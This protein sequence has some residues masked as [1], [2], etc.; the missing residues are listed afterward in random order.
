[1]RSTSLQLASSWF[2]AVLTCI[3]AAR[4][5]TVTGRVTDASGVGIAGVVVEFSNGAAP[6]NPVTGLDGSFV[7]IVPGRVYDEITFRP[8]TNAHA[9]ILLEDV[10]ISGFTNLGTLVMQPGLAISGVVTNPSGGPQ[11]GVDIDVVDQSTGQELFTPNDGTNALGQFSV[12]VPAGVHTVRFTPPTA[13]TFAAEQRTDVVVNAATSVGTVMFRDGILLSGTV[14]D[15]ATNQP[16]NNV[17]IDVDDAF[18]GQRVF[19]PNDNTDAMG[20][21]S[22]RVPRGLIHLS[23]DPAPGVGF[24]ASQQFNLGAS[25]NTNVGAIALDRG[26]LLRGAVRGPGNVP[27]ARVAV[28][29]FDPRGVEIY[30]PHDIT[31]GS[32]NFVVAV[33][34]GSYRL[35][36]VPQIASQLAGATSSLFSVAAGT[37][38]NAPTLNLPAGVRLS[39]RVTATGGGAEADAEIQVFDPTSGRQLAV[40]GDETLAD[41]S[42]VAWLPSGTWRVRIE[43]A[44]GSASQ[45]ANLGN[46]N[47]T[48]PTV[49]NRVLAA[50][51]ITVDV[52]TFGIPNV[53]PGGILPLNLTIQHRGNA[54]LP[55]TIAVSLFDVTGAEYPFVPPIIQLLFPV[56]FQATAFASLWTV[57]ASLP[58]SL[59]GEPVRYEFRL[60]DP[61]TG[62]VFDRGSA[63]FILR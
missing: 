33:P 55:A 19:T 4:A 39:G 8:P 3:G 50:A 48:A 28:S 57:P 9:P 61:T 26:V 18:S 27:V 21:F 58:A 36:G 14:V 13:T 38:A 30:T 31:D 15:R 54:P 6:A 49:L 7:L 62:A 41:G 34:P 17:D 42:Y 12:I 53:T 46:V 47:V 63:T 16:I 44:I 24:V 25:Q 37:T 59:R 60:Q 43:P 40:P 29:L 35:T 1:M 23:V 11:I 5:D 51:P 20:R 2:T 32:G 52:S 45:P 22:V 56:G 10:S